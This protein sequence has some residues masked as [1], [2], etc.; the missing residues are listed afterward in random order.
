MAT[1]FPRVLLFC[2]TDKLTVGELPNQHG[3]LFLSGT[4]ISNAGDNFS[5]TDL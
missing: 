5:W 4:E 2:G 3:K 1:G